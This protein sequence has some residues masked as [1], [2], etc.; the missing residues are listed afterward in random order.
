MFTALAADAGGVNHLNHDAHAHTPEPPAGDQDESRHALQLGRRR[1]QRRSH[2]DPAVDRRSLPVGDGRQ[3]ATTTSTGCCTTPATHELERP[4][5]TT[6]TTCSSPIRTLVDPGRPGRCRR[7]QRAPGPD[8]GSP[9]S[10]ARAFTPARPRRGEPRPHPGRRCSSCA[11]GYGEFDRA[12]GA[13]ADVDPVR[14]L[15]GTAAG[16]GGLPSA[17]ATYVNVD[18]GLPVGE[19]EITVRR[20]PRRRLLVD[21]ALQRRRATSTT[22]AAPSAS[23]TSPRSATPTAP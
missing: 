22:T 14:H 10:P 17:E 23:T 6:P 13:R 18:P 8:L 1:H 11:K 3:P 21:L 4:T 12:F 19:Y 15:V 9:P 16:W 20:R 7:G 5:A 2:P